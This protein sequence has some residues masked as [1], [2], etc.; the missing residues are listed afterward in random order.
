MENNIIFIAEQDG[1][2]EREF[3]HALIELFT[4]YN[5]KIRAYLVLTA[6]SESPDDHKVM[7]C[8]VTDKGEDLEL[9]KH[10]A[11]QFRL[12]FSNNQFLD[13]T[14]LTEQH[15]HV[16]RQCCCPFFTS[17][18]FQVSQPDFYLFSTEGYHLNDQVRHCFMRQR[19]HSDRPDGF[20]LCDISPPLI[21]QQF[22]LGEEDISQVLMAIRYEGS[23][24]FPISE[25]PLDIYVLRI[26]NEH[27]HR[28]L[29]I[30]TED[31]ELIG[32]AELYQ[33][34]SIP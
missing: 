16:L 11:Q 25:W 4:Q 19:L 6:S 9:L 26:I 12:V 31:Y 29:E 14:F 27:V 33:D 5:G 24:L 22:G 21:G 30:K 28:Q 32:L 34:E 8:L 17:D 20:L 15:E 3:K 2:I 18:D 10:C 7:L 1:V 13:I 23:S